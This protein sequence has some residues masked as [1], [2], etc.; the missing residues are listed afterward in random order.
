[1]NI[2]KMKKSQ[3]N[4]IMEW[5]PL[6]KVRK[7][8]RQKGRKKERKKER[9]KVKTV[10]KCCRNVEMKKFSKRTNEDE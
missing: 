3:N 7:K 1:M 10:D 9:N 2:K 8:E 4:K 5:L 6:Q